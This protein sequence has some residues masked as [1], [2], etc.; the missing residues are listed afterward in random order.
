MNHQIIITCEHAGN[1]VPKEYTYLFEG[2]QDLLESPT[3]WDPGA[4]DISKYI[5]E[6]FKAQ[7]FGCFST[8]LLVEANRSLHHPH[9]FSEYTFPLS[10]DDKTRLLNKIY[11]PYRSQV[12]DAMK[13]LA[14]PILHLSFHTFS[15]KWNGQTRKVDIGILFDPDR[16]GEEG[17]ANGLKDHLQYQLPDLVIRFNDPFKGI[18]DGFTTYF[19]KIMPD[20]QYKGIEIE[21]NQKYVGTD[22]WPVLRS[23]LY[24]SLNHQLSV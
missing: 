23:A 18:D 13:K 22:T 16:P 19:R 12:M 8:R 15:P 24:R 5:A 11:F 9:L 7:A 3:S 1:Y 21:I 2:K 4:W 17:F 10:E 20:G 14:A 6:H